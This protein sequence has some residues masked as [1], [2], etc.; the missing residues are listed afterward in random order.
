MAKHWLPL[1]AAALALTAGCKTM[2]GETAGQNLDD[3][4][5]TASVKSHLATQERIGT[6]TQINVTTVANTVY[7][8]GIVQTAQE[9]QRAEDIARQVNGVK[10]VV[11][12]IEVR[13]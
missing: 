6:L 5:I 8:S 10:R 3:S 7:L 2:T 13:S 4:A 11:N 9:K 1:I 12:N